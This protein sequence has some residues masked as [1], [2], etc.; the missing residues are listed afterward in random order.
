M[1]T[2]L[3]DG[4]VRGID[5]SPDGRMFVSASGGSLYLWD[6]ILSMTSVPQIAD[7]NGDGSV[8]IQDLVLVASNFPKIG[9]NAADVNGDFTETEK[10]LIRK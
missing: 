1:K 5:F 10:M 7:V 8:N 4:Y 6:I 9:D 2:L 3:V